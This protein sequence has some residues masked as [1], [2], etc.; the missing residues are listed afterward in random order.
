MKK[1]LFDGAGALGIDLTEQGAEKLLLYLDELLKWNQQINLTS[2]S[3]REQ[4]VEKH[5]LDSLA[6]I[7]VTEG[8]EKILDIGSGAGLPG[9]ILALARPEL[10]VFSVESVGKKHN[11]QKN[12]KRKLKIDNLIVYRTRIE[13]LG[14]SDVPY[15][16]FDLVTARAFASLDLL[17][18]VAEPWLKESGVLVAMKGPEG[19]EELQKIADV[20]KNKQM[21]SKSFAYRL[22][23]SG[24]ERL[25]I[26]LKKITVD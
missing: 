5:L 17:L 22:P 2:I 20:I 1:K 26:S 3:D 13:D 16:S 25:L 21:K 12:I 18:G 7:K 15:N 9:I 14:L 11:F 19:Q 23:Y 4:A 24:A 8:G 6:L 10:T